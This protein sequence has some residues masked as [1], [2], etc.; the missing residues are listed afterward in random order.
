MGISANIP[1]ASNALE[2]ARA[3]PPGTP[4]GVQRS[5]VV[6]TLG[7]ENVATRAA[8]TIA[9]LVVD[10]PDTVVAVV[11]VV[12]AVASDDHA[13]ALVTVAG[14]E[15]AATVV[16]LGDL[17]EDVHQVEVEGLDQEADD[18]HR[19][20]ALPSL[21]LLN[22][23]K[24]P[25]K[26]PPHQGGHPLHLRDALL[27]N[28]VTIGRILANALLAINANSPMVTAIHVLILLPLLWMMTMILTLTIDHAQLVALVV[29]AP[30]AL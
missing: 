15:P 19:R 21:H 25:R 3:L 6:V 29:L 4:A 11:V 10:T 16:I 1:I 18:D 23:P 28:P 22:D 13:M 24:T 8:E 14:A 30:L 27:A 20:Q 12:R 9:V 17:E 26:P 5:V 2:V 7:T